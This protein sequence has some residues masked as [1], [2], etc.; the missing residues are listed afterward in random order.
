MDLGLA[1]VP[2]GGLSKG[3]LAL[4]QGFFDPDHAPM[5]QLDIGTILF[6]GAG[7]GLAVSFA[8]AAGVVTAR[9]FFRAT[10]EPEDKR[11]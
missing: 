4:L 3:L 7:L 1:V 5:A 9:V 6:A 8:V 10:S 11:L 2:A